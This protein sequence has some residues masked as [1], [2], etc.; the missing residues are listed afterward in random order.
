PAGRVDERVDR[1]PLR[2]GEDDLRRR[3]ALLLGR[4][5]EREQ[6]P[7]L[8]QRD[9]RA[10]VCM[11]ERGGGCSQGNRRRGSEREGALHVSSFRICLDQVVATD[12]T[13]GPRGA[14]AAATRAERAWAVELKTRPAPRSS[15]SRAASRTTSRR[16]HASRCSTA[17]WPA[18]ATSERAP[19]T[20]TAS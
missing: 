12:P 2:E 20:G 19:R 1:E 10:D 4:H 18:T 13:G 3:R 16:A 7:R 9:G 11:C 6:L 14:A 8:R 15:G 5:V 17:P